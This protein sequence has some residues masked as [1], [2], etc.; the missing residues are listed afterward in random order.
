[1]RNFLILLFLIGAFLNPEPLSADPFDKLLPYPQSLIPKSG[2]FK[3]SRHTRFYTNAPETDRQIFGDQLSAMGENIPFTT[4]R[5]QAAIQL[6]IDTTGSKETDAYHLV[7]SPKSVVIRAATAKGLFYGIQTLRQ[8]AEPADHSF[9]IPSVEI[10][11]YARFG[12]RG[13]HLDVSR[14]FYPVSFIKK[15]LNALAYYKMNTFHWHLTDGAGWRLQLKKYPE[16]T[17]KAAWRKSPDWKT[18]WTG[19]RKYATEGD[20]DAFGGYYTHED[21]KEVLDYASKR[22]ITVIPEIEMPGHSEEVLAV[23]PELSCTGEP[24]KHGEFCAGND[25]VFTFLENVLDEVMALFPSEYIHIGGDEAAKGAWKV[26]PKCQKRIRDNQLKNEDELQSYFVHRIEKYLNSKGRKM[27]GWDEILEGGLSKSATVMSWRGEEGGIKAAKAGNQVVMTPGEY[28]YLDQYQDNPMTEPEAIGGYLPLGRVYSY[29]PLNIGLTADEKKLIKGIQGNVWTEYLSTIEKT[30]Q[31]MYPRLLA[32]CEVAWTNPEVKDWSRF[33]SRVSNNMGV[34]NKMGIS[35]KPLSTLITQEREVDLIN[36]I[37]RVKLSADLDSVDIYYTTDG[38]DPSESSLRYK[39]PVEFHE[40]SCVKAQIYKNG[41]PISGVQSFTVDI[42]KGLGMPIDV[43]KYLGGYAAG[44]KGALVDGQ[45]GTYSYRDQ[46]W[47]GYVK[48]IE[49][50]V[51]L[52]E[53]QPINE[54]RACFMQLVG[55]WIWLPK[56]VEYAVSDDRETFTPVATLTHDVPVDT[57]RMILRDF[58]FK[59]NASGRYVRMR[60]KPIDRVGAVMFVDELII[61]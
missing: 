39:S 48:N 9:V 6:L 43:S 46:K 32:L 36:K 55:P 59:G 21:V 27:I 51:D 30:E 42:H 11:D 8:L 1:M 34:L 53:V 15:H 41:N 5:K 16:L 54:I 23:Y 12:Y 56:E 35:P 14:H 18:W 45:I 19:D 29:D 10:A 33:R 57:D 31:R 7:V 2:A 49:C 24:Y 3:M 50:I 28:C 37:I 52:G 58:T 60:V 26:C 61:N 17:Q 22:F 38:S 47:Q 44:G 40:T 25:S 4:K 20:S 13:L